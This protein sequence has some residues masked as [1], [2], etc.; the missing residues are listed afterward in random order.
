VLGGCCAKL[1]ALYLGGPVRAAF[2]I[3]T[4]RCPRRTVAAVTKSAHSLLP[5][6]AP[7]CAGRFSSVPQF[8]QIKR[9]RMTYIGIYPDTVGVVTTLQ[10]CREPV[11]RKRRPKRSKV[12]CAGWST[13]E[14]ALTHCS[15]GDLKRFAVSSVSIML[16]QV[17]D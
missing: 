5:H 4:A 17:V 8:L 3:P 16:C 10:S 12:S 6:G 7:S 13:P 15:L 2:L 9:R 11:L 1:V 14:G